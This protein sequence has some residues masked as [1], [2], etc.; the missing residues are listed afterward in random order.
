M[1]AKKDDS[2]PKR[3]GRINVWVGEKPA[4]AFER[5]LNLW[6]QRYQVDQP[7]FRDY[8]GSRPAG[9]RTNVDPAAAYRF[10][11]LPVWERVRFHDHHDELARLGYDLRTFEGVDR[12]KALTQPER[13]R[14]FYVVQDRD[15]FIEQVKANYFESFRSYFK[16]FQKRFAEFFED[17]EQAE[18]S[19]DPENLAAHYRFMNLTAQSTIAQIRDRYRTLAFRMHPDQGGD[20]EKMKALNIAYTAIMQQALTR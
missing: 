6:K 3:G 16:D 15:R 11:N 13:D 5:H 7:D 2:T 20:M 4:N 8:R 18:P 1:S 9:D 17:F 14:L 12:F 19:Y 10:D